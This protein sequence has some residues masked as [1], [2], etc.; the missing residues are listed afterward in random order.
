MHFVKALFII[1]VGQILKDIMKSSEITNY[2]YRAFSSGDYDAAI[3]YFTH[4][5]TKSS[6]YWS[7]R[8]YLSMSYWYSGKTGSA[9][10]ALKDI[11]E[12]C[13]DNDLKQKALFA[14]RELTA[15]DDRL[16]GRNSN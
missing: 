11:S 2:G 7:G 15:A 5:D 3:K 8:L 4:L 6:S 1:L 10:Q 13:P 12:W 9:I 14:L 16:F